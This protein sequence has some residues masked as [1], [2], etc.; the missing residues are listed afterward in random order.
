MTEHTNFFSNVS[1]D[2]FATTF[3]STVLKEWQSYCPDGMAQLSATVLPMGIPLVAQFEFKRGSKEAKYIKNSLSYIGNDKVFFFLNEYGFINIITEKMRMDQLTSLLKKFEGG[4]SDLQL[5][6]LKLLDNVEFK[7]LDSGIIEIYFIISVVA[8]PPVNEFLSYSDFQL[9]GL[10]PF[11]F[12]IPMKQIQFEFKK[13]TEYWLDAINTKD[14]LAM[15]YNIEV[16][17]EINHHYYYINGDDWCYE[18]MCN[19]GQSLLN[20]IKPFEIGGLDNLVTA[21]VY[22]MPRQRAYHHLG[23]ERSIWLGKQPVDLAS[24]TSVKSF[25]QQAWL[26]CSVDNLV[27]SWNF[28]GFWAADNYLI[29]HSQSQSNIH[30][31]P[32]GLV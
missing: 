19:F 26:T 8:C 22:K 16:H 28:P 3:S 17:L 11:N 23:T 32:D 7:Q 6:S 25:C 4:I 15:V 20:G 18:L 10:E 9:S 29:F 12:E 31:F 14:L 5:D 1:N 21:S 13:D 30:S 24:M 2:V 27:F